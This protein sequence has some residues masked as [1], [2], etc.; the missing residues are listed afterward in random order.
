VHRTNKTGLL[1]HDLRE[2][3]FNPR[4]EAFR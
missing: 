3:N 2:Y 4:H 1:Q